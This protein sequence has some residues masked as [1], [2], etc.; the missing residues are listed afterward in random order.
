MNCSA[1]AKRDVAHL[2]DDPERG[3]VSPPRRQRSRA[4][5]ARPGSLLGRLAHVALERLDG[6]VDQIE[7]PE[8]VVEGVLLSPERE[9]LRD[10]PGPA[11]SRLST[12]SGHRALVAQQGLRHPL[13]GAHA[14]EAVVGAGAQ[15]ITRR[16]ELARGDKDRLE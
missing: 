14:V 15:Q 12:W 13:A 10:Q 16:L 3:R 1:V 2:A 11:A 9:R 8:V 5:S 4:T 6:A 7:R